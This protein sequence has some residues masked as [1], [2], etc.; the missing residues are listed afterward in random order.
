MRIGR[1]RACNF[2]RMN[3]L[4]FRMH[5]TLNTWRG[6]HSMNFSL[7]SLIAYLHD[8]KKRIFSSS[9]SLLRAAATATR[10][11]ADMSCRWCAYGHGCSAA[12]KSPLC[13]YAKYTL[14][15]YSVNVFGNTFDNRIF[16][17]FFRTRKKFNGTHIHFN[18]RFGMHSARE[19]FH[20]QHQIE[21]FIA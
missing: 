17:G 21:Y 15:M 11:V 7:F 10:R 9:H 19:R 8:S 14:C 13:H 5:N 3:V 16:A 20:S 12:S 6:S 18:A 2:S 4:S 1:I